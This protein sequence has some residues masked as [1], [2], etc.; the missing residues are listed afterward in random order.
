MNADKLRALI[1]FAVVLALGSGVSVFCGMLIERSSD[2]RFKAEATEFSSS[3]GMPGALSRERSLEGGA[4]MAAYSL[5]KQ[6]APGAY[7]LYLE[8][9]GFSGKAGFLSALAP[10]GAI[11]GTRP[12]AL[13]DASLVNGAW[14]SDDRIKGAVAA[15]EGAA[16]A[17][18]LGTDESE[19]VLRNLA[20]ALSEGRSAIEP[21]QGGSR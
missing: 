12:L 7:I 4:V 8:C 1:A 5:R 15:Q 2:R 10:N 13:T 16:A 20:A 9:R 14:P 21:G 18:S 3:L 11:R 6:G 17:R 19:F